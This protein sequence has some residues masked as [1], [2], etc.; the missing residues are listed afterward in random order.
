MGE[1]QF[2]VRSHEYDDVIEISLRRVPLD[3]RKLRQTQS[4]T[5][6]PLGRWLREQY[7]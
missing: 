3:K 5:E 7:M 4:D 6:H 1:S 2:V